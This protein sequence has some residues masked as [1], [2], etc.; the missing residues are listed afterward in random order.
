MYEHRCL[1]NIKKFYKYAGK[2][3][4]QQ[5]YKV[6]LEEVMVYTPEGFNNNSTRSPRQYVTVKYTSSIKSLHNV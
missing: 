2:C 4:G 3:N 5:Q 6:F 1:E